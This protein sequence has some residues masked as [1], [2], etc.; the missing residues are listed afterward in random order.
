[1]NG[2][3]NHSKELIDAHNHIPPVE[4]RLKRQ[5]PEDLSVI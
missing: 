5:S 1:M 2:N 3:L 4:R